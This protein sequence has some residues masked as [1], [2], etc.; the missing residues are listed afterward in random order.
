MRLAE[1][2]VVNRNL[3]KK[4][5]IGLSAWEICIGIITVFIYA[6]YVKNNGFVITQG[7]SMDVVSAELLSQ[8]L[9]IVSFTIGMF[10]LVLGCINFYLSKVIKHN[11]TEKRIPIWFLICAV[12]SFFMMDVVSVGMLITTS[13]IILAKNKAI[14]VHH[15]LILTH[16]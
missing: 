8:N 7:S 12:I 11:V 4:M 9:F 15:D 1:K 10:S 16:K 2:T 3:E 13:I 6:P 5:I 14:K